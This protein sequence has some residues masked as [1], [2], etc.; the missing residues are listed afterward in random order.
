[1]DPWNEIWK[2]RNENRNVKLPMTHIH[3]HTMTSNQLVDFHDQRA[4][5]VSIS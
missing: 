5:T 3:T 2:V 1:M 4:K